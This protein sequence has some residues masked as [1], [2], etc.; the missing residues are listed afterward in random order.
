M[1]TRN[2]TRNPDTHSSSD[3]PSL[4]DCVPILPA[5]E[6]FDE[7]PRRCIRIKVNTY[8]SSSF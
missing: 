8:A 4:G 5:N 6:R 2:S 3:A 1:S 7:R